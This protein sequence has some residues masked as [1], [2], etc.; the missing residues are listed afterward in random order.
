MYRMVAGACLLAGLLLL[1]PTHAT[2][3]PI[4]S[5]SLQRRYNGLPPRYTP[6]ST[7]SYKYEGNTYTTKGGST[8]HRYKYK[9][10]SGRTYKGTTKSLPGGSYQHKGRWK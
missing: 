1:A 2:A 8:L 3:D 9:S 4:V 6:P 7:K 5:E 10:P